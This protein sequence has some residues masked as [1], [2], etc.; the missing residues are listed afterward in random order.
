MRVR[1]DISN[2][3]SLSGTIPKRFKVAHLTSV[4]SPFDIRIFHKECRALSDSGFEVVTVAP[5]RE[6]DDNVV[7][8]VCTHRVSQPKTR[9][10]R[11]IRTVWQVFRAGR[12]EAADTYHFHDPELIPAGLLLKL[13]GKRV[14][15]D[16]HEDLPRQILSKAWIPRPLR[17]PI[18]LIAETCEWLGASSFDG[19]VAATPAIAR[20]FPSEKTITVQNFPLPDELRPSVSVPFTQ[21][22]ARVV[23]LGRIDLIRGIREM[24]LAMERLSQVPDAKLILAGRFDSPR[25]LDEVSGLPGW[26]RVNYL[27]WKSRSD[28]AELLAD[29]QAGLVILHPHAHFLESYP[30]KLF[31]YMAAGIPVIASDFPLWRDIVNKASCGILVNPRDTASIAAAILWVFQH[32]QEAQLMGQRGWNAIRTKYNWVFEAAKL[33]AFYRRLFQL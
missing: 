24:V 4:H 30:I 8:G 27:G 9:W 25:L 20:R 22:P 14:I 32:P 26:R 31:E 7:H 23:Y 33:T 12:R 15:Y 11:L 18:A 10:Q 3:A 21:R 5:C 28:I 13:I 2:E 29:V 1:L 6:G 17:R 16:V 19:I